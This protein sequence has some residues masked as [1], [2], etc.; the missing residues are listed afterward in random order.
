MNNKRGYSPIR[1]DQSLEHVL[2]PARR[3]GPWV[4]RALPCEAPDAVKGVAPGLLE[5]SEGGLRA[6]RS[7]SI[8]EVLESVPR[9]FAPPE[10]DGEFRH[11]GDVMSPRSR[12]GDRAGLGLERGRVR[13]VVCY[14][15]REYLS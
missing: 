9:R 14:Q 6:Y 10:R 11:G 2:L 4:Q 5:D 8:F 15:R 1:I 7:G 3:F 13:F 12:L